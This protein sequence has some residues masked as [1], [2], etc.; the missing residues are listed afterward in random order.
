[1]TT[2]TTA[3]AAICHV[4]VK[5]KRNNRHLL[6]ESLIYE[7]FKRSHPQFQNDMLT[8]FNAFF[9]DSELEYLVLEDYGHDL[10]STYHLDCYLRTTI[11]IPNVLEALTK[12]HQMKIIHGNLKPENILVSSDD[13]YRVK[14]CDFENACHFDENFPRHAYGHGGHRHD[15]SNDHDRDEHHENLKLSFDWISPML[16]FAYEEEMKS[17][18][19]TS[20]VIRADPKMDMFPLALI[21]DL[22][23]RKVLPKGDVIMLPNPLIDT[24]HSQ[25]RE[26]FLHPQQQLYPRTYCLSHPSS[27]PY[28]HPYAA[29]IE[30]MLTPDDCQ[31]AEFYF[32]SIQQFSFFELSQKSKQLEQERQ[33][34]Q[35]LI[36]MLEE[37]TTATTTSQQSDDGGGATVD[38]NEI[39]FLVNQFQEE[40][41]N[42][43]AATAA[44][45]T[46]AATATAAAREIGAATAA[47]TTK[48]EK[49]EIILNQS[50]ES[51]DQALRAIQTNQELKVFCEQ[52]QIY[53][54]TKFFDLFAAAMEKNFLY[55]KS[56]EG[57]TPTMVE[58]N[59]NNNNNSSSGSSS[60]D[61]INEQL[62]MISKIAM[63][64]K[65]ASELNYQSTVGLSERQ[66]KLFQALLKI[67]ETLRRDA[68]NFHLKLMNLKI[69]IIESLESSQV[70]PLTSAA[71]TR[72]GEGITAE[73]RAGG[74]IGAVLA[75]AREAR[76]DQQVLE[77]VQAMAKDLTLTKE[78]LK[79]MINDVKKNISAVRNFQD[80]SAF[81]AHSHPVLFVLSDEIIKDGKV[82][83]VIEN[84]SQKFRQVFRVHFLCTVCG[85]KAPSGYPPGHAPGHASP[86]PTAAGSHGHHH[87]KKYTWYH[88]LKN[89]T[90]HVDLTQSGYRLSI[91]HK[92]VVEIFEVLKIV[93]IAIQ[94]SVKLAGLPFP[95]I[96][97]WSGEGGDHH[98][99]ENFRKAVDDVDREV[100]KIIENCAKSLKKNHKG[101]SIQQ[102]YCDD[103]GDGDGDAKDHVQDNDSHPA[104][105]GEGGE[106][107]DEGVSLKSF[108]AENRPQVTWNDVKIVKLLLELMGDPEVQRT[109]L[110]RCIR[111]IDGSCA[112]VCLGNERSAMCS[113]SGDMR[114]CSE[115]Y[116]AEGDACCLIKMSF[117]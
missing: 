57:W 76:D 78:E 1:L 3:T 43:T 36:Q 47:I 73:T 112:W 117:V 14:L 108:W 114:S 45:E 54:E 75:G 23:C 64:A 18:Q 67:D 48:I 94:I 6:H 89:A 56:I 44:I 26:C 31:T 28:S 105:D 90:S 11:L 13:S 8:C 109:G 111:R 87:E 95:N 116:Q 4:A 25:L 59:N 58:T 72:V 91:P 99:F 92:W 70:S 39:K 110:Q 24:D 77:N 16:F 29:I 101:K 96:S 12:L 35:R 69:E 30:Q 66:D 103:G 10:R 115:L 21:F 104:D 51:F 46:V 2:A 40:I 55:Q 27:P 84:A 80:H 100:Q 9:C 41:K 98:F 19:Q 106:G 42:M 50:F 37:I 85:K 93:M 65:E 52:I 107:G 102:Q 34:S 86:P 79:A 20:L 60:S 17:S 71:G 74:G 113:E 33:L 82:P 22:L 88:S 97:S 49:L 83:A 61:E 53:F 63:E 32:D 38:V 62:K 5:L 68:E 7:C 81:N 15:Q